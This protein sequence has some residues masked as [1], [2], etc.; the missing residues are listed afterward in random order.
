MVNPIWTLEGIM[1]VHLNLNMDLYVT[2]CVCTIFLK[3]WNITLWRLI[4]FKVKK[5][6]EKPYLWR[7]KIIFNFRKVQNGKV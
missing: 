4:A 1:L 3:L 5:R 7:Y 2:T 6:K